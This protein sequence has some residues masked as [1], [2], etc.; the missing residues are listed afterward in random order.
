MTDDIFC[1]I[2][3]ILLQSVIIGCSMEISKKNCEFI[4]PVVL[5]LLWWERKKIVTYLGWCTFLTVT[6][7]KIKFLNIMV[8]IILFNIVFCWKF[9]YLKKWRKVCFSYMYMYVDK[10]SWNSF[11]KSRSDDIMESGFIL[12]T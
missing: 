2:W 6:Y 9:Y 12:H 8:Q 4:K 10:Y 3:K 1:W 5:S 7:W 11:F